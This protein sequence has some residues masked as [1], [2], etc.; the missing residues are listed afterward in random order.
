MAWYRDSFIYTTLHSSGWKFPRSS[1][2]QTW[3]LMICGDTKVI[4]LQFIFSITGMCQC[5]RKWVPFVC[6]HVYLKE[7]PYAASYLNTNSVSRRP[8]TDVVMNTQYSS[9]GL[10]LILLPIHK[11]QDGKYNYCQYWRVSLHMSL[12]TTIRKCNGLLPGLIQ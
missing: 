8:R 10:V 11:F 12:R 5:V 7:K 1:C 2:I 9:L 4:H 3:T 6:H